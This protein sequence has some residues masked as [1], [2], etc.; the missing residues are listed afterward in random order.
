L[1]A[2][3]LALKLEA[4]GREG[5]LYLVDSAPDF[6]KA[7]LERSIGENN[8]QFENNVICTMFNIIAPHEA[9]SAAISKVHHAQM[10]NFK[11]LVFCN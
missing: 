5:N 4:E 2:L 8:D 10:L 1:L 9:T 7:L 11:I 3:E 6:M